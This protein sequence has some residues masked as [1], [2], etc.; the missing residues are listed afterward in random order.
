M[1]RLASFQGTLSETDSKRHLE[2]TFTCPPG[3]EGLELTLT[4]EPAEVIGVHDPGYVFY[5]STPDR[6]CS[7]S[8][9]ALAELLFQK[10]A[11]NQQPVGIVLVKVNDNILQGRV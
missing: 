4:F 9:I 11:V 7:K 5:A 10:P 3:A 2:F 1:T 6:V 8:Q